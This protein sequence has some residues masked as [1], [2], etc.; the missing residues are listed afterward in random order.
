MRLAI[1]D[2]LAPPLGKQPRHTG[3]NKK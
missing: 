3:A 2:R 1:Y